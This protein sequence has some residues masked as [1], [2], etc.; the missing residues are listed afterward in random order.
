MTEPKLPEIALTDDEVDEILRC[1]ADRAV[2]VGG[3][4]LAVWASTYGVLTAEHAENLTLDADFL[5]GTRAATALAEAL[6]PQG[7]RLWLAA[8]DDATPQSAKLSKRIEG[9]GIKRIDFLHHLVGMDT[10]AVRRRAVRMTLADGTRL[11]VLHPLDVLESRFRNLASLSSKRNRFGVAQARLSIDVAR[12]YLHALLDGDERT[13]L[14][15]IERIV[16]LALDTRLRAVLHG[17]GLDPLQAVPAE[18]VPSQAFRERRWP[19][20]VAQWQRHR[21]AW[22]KHQAREAARPAS[23]RKPTRQGADQAN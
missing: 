16:R 22:Q 15:A 3:Q 14:E 18:Q 5:G 19:Q 2:L 7:W 10:E 8:I 21:E 12:H 9:V 11:A 23:E 17:T 4:A 6:R 20:V 1:C 13:L